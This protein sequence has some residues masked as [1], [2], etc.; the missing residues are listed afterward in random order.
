M[1]GILLVLQ[2]VFA[3]LI[4]IVVMMQKSSSMGLGAYSGSNESLFG[5][6]GPAGFLAKLTFGLGLLFVLNTIALGYLYT[7]DAKRSIV[8]GANIPESS[9][10]PAVPVAPDNTESK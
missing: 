8:D 6:K 10:V 1:S 3:I 4:T 5:A 7:Q 9:V 2:F